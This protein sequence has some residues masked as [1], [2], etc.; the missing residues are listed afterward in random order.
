MKGRNGSIIRDVKLFDLKDLV[1]G[2]GDIENHL[3]ITELIVTL[4]RCQP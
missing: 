3:L 1:F 4:T 2:T